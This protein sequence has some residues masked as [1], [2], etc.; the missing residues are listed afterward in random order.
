MSLREELSHSLLTL[1]PSLLFKELACLQRAEIPDF[2]NTENTMEQVLEQW[3]LGLHVWRCFHPK[4]MSGAD[5]FV[6]ETLRR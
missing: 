5:G 4:E 6:Q 3:G 2:I 1:R